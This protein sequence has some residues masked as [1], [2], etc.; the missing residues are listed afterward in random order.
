MIG[1]VDCN[2]F[3]ASCERVFNPQLRDK[4]VV[5]LSNNDGCIIAR[6]NEAK[7]IGL[8]MGDPFFR[9][10]GIL[11][12]NGVAVFSSNYNL[13]GDMSRRVMLLLSEL[14]PGIEQ[15]S[16]DECFVDL[17]G[18]D[19]IAALGHHVVRT[20]GKGTGIPVTMG[21][22][23]SKTLAKVASRFGKRCAGYAG[24]CVIDSEVKR[25]KALQ[26]TQVGDVWGIGRQSADKLTCRG[27]NTAWDLAG[28]KET[29]V[30][31]LLGITGVRTWR[32]L[33]GEDCIDIGEL[34]QKKSIC[35]SRSFPDSGL[36]RLSDVE[37]A[38]ANFAASCARKLREQR[39]VCR[40][41]T[42]VAF[43][44]RW[45][46]DVPSHAVNRTV[47]FAVPTA[48]TQE[49]VASAVR[50][51]RDDAI[52]GYLY[53]KAGVIVWDI[54]SANAV[55]GDLFDTIDRARQRRLSLAI[56]DINRRNGHNMVRVAVQGFGKSWHIKTEHLS[57]RYTTNIDDV[58]RVKS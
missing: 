8:N 26:L 15:Y 6:S 14:T 56:D 13:Y 47:V 5:V 55:Q 29:W 31:R 58:I 18:I 17:D 10:K 12:H 44:S 7:A 3:Y 46:N 21:V 33:N 40:A 41:V 23:T 50:V 36:S 4:P 35:T 45:R 25:A 1:L 51:V 30:R 19:D 37:E 2:N 52:E 20:I 49:I 28:Q 9:V 42:V 53:K 48:D 54:C 27:V 43:T 16:I 22:G 38:V 32:E 24:V 11:E 34:P 57:R 39:S